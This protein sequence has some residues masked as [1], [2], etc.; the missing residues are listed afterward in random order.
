MLFGRVAELLPASPFPLHMRA[1]SL[2]NSAHYPE[3]LSTYASALSVD[4]SFSQSYN[5][6]GILLVKMGQ[7]K[8]ALDAYKDAIRVDP[9]YADPKSNMQVGVSLQNGRS[10]RKR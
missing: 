4:P 5:N 7:V 8:E 10:Q 1:M 2:A 3:A 9:A 6:L